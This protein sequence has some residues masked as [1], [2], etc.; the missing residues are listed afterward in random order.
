MVEQHHLS[1]YS[2]VWQKKHSLLIYSYRVELPT[3]KRV[4]KW[5]ISLD[6]LMTDPLGNDFKRLNL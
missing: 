3:E 1:S 2:L 5:G 6:N 4:R